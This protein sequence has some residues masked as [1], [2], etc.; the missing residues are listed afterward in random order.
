MVGH[1]GNADPAG[2]ALKNFDVVNDVLRRCVTNHAMI[3]HW[4]ELAGPVLD[5]L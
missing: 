2:A 3:G 1:A 4:D 5:A